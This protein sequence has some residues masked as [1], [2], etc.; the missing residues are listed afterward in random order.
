MGSSFFEFNIATTG[1]FAARAGLEIT[2]HNVSNVATPGYSRQYIKQ[3]AGIPLDRYSGVGQ[4]GTGTVVYGIGQHRDV[5]LDQKYWP[6]VSTLGEYSQKSSQLS[7]IETSLSELSKTSITNNVNDFFKS[8]S[9]L[10]FSAD[11]LEYRMAVIN[12]ADTLVTN[13]R[14]HA[15]KLRQQQIDLND[16]AYALVERINSI[17]T[18]IASLNDQ[19]YTYEL[20]G[21]TANELRDQRALLIDEL[22]KYVNVEVKEY[23]DGT[24]REL[25]KKY[26]VLLNGQEFV[27][28]KTSRKLECIRRENA[29][30]PNDPPGLYDIKWENGD[31]LNLKT[32]TGELK[33]ILDVRDGDSGIGGGGSYKGIPYYIDKLN[34]FVR[35][36]AYAMNTGKRLSDDGDLEGV[37][38]HQDGFDMKGNKGGLLFSMVDPTTGKTVT[39]IAD[40]S[41]INVFN[42]AISDEIKAD[43][44]K[45][46]ISDTN[47]STQ[48]SNNKVVL[49]FLKLKDDTSLFAEGG[50][51]QFVN[52][53]SAT[54]GIDT[55]QANSFTSFYTDVTK[56][57][58][59]QRMQVSAV[60]INEE[61]T[62]MVKYQHLYQAASKLMNVINEVYNTTING[63]GV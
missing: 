57:I 25:D 52:A 37:I 42:F 36:M 18:Q 10:A 28:H 15:T 22:S 46:A 11:S 17:G 31:E 40:Y 13:I 20:D 38:G 53:I 3:K 24:G 51:Y 41:D 59:N 48:E 21:N 7:L 29:L 43:P 12:N 32:L 4:V 8:I 54:L 56:T 19:I 34:E 49:G 30:H 63:L 23:S 60:S 16:D 44:S 2:S 6:Q 26:V 33:G 35:T 1:L 55:K 14:N 61:I 5:Y 45:L 47:D 62:N 9:D 50:A 58:D 39:N 27:D